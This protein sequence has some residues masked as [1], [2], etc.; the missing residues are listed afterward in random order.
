MVAYHEECHPITKAP[1]FFPQLTKEGLVRRS[2]DLILLLITYTSAKVSE[3]FE[4]S[5]RFGNTASRT[6]CLGVN[7][8]DSSGAA[9]NHLFG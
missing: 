2:T 7:G 9:V 8:F 3:L 5:A 1:A 6:L 4:V